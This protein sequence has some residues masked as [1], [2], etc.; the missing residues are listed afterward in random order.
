MI[1]Y[2]KDLKDSTEKVLDLINIF[3]KLAG[4]QIN[5]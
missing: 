4:Y 1:L 2:S 3:S 5:I